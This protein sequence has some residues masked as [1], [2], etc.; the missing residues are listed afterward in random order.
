MFTDDENILRLSGQHQLPSKLIHL[1]DGSSLNFLYIQQVDIH[2]CSQIESWVEHNYRIGRQ[3]SELGMDH[4]RFLHTCTKQFE[5]SISILIPINSPL[6]SFL[7]TP[8]PY[9]SLSHTQTQNGTI[10]YLNFFIFPVVRFGCGFLGRQTHCRK[11][12]MFFWLPA[13]KETTDSQIQQTT[14]CSAVFLLL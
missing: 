3:G 14:T 12:H 4:F 11:W 13:E 2:F 1:N 7:R 9:F 8:L 5:T 6:I 10:S